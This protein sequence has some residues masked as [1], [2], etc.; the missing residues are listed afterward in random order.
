MA[1]TP[2]RTIAFQL[3]PQHPARHRHHPHR[4]PIIRISDGRSS[5]GG[6]TATVFAATGFLGRYIVNPLVPPAALSWSP[7]ATSTPSAIST[8]SG[9]LGRVIFIECDLRNIT[10][11]KESVR[12]SDIVYNLLGWYYRTN[13]FNFDSVH[14]EGTRRIV[15][16]V[17]K[18]DTNSFVQVSTHSANPQ[19]P[20]R[21]HRTKY[22]G[23]STRQEESLGDDG[24]AA[25]AYVRVRR[26]LPAPLGER[27][28]LAQL[29]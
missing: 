4:Q 22:Q 21:Y 9:D 2:A 13:K 17:A 15:E 14:V 16:A 18:Y 3:P 5:L 26:P 27:D 8:S 24:G 11:I 19:S 29:Q 23:E 7:S 6:H 25:S 1:G 20:S 10:S 28:E 12:H